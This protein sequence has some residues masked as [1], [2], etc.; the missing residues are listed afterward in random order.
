[1]T[2]L[3]QEKEGT[4]KYHLVKWEI[5]CMPQDQ[6]G[7]GV[8]DLRV[9][10]FCLMCKWLWK[11]ETT[12]GLWQNLIRAKYLKDKPLSQC[13]GK[14]G[15]SHFWQGVIKT[16]GTFSRCCRK[17]IGNG[18]RTLFWEDLWVGDK[19]L[20]EKFPRLYFLTVNFTV[21]R[22]FNEGWGCIRFR[23]VLF[24][25]TAKLWQELKN[26]CQ[27][28]TLSNVEDRSKWLLTKN[29]VFTVKSLYNLL[30]TQ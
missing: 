1:V 21:A 27:N 25:E 14:P 20:R 30:K 22:V 18:Q 12:D 23:R 7:L 3:W 9:M 16:A 19:P 17:I 15:D 24:G 26:L 28:V 4:K 29:G 8:V 10:N 13:V 2:L 6:V 11:L 5:V